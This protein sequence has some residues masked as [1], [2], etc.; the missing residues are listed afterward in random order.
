MS[1]H[2]VITARGAFG[3]DARHGGFE[4]DNAKLAVARLFNGMMDLLPESSSHILY[5]DP[6]AQRIS[7]DGACTGWIG[8][9]PFKLFVVD[10]NI[11][12]SDFQRVVTSYSDRSAGS[13]ARKKFKAD[14]SSILQ[15]DG[16]PARKFLQTLIHKSTTSRSD[17]VL[18]IFAQAVGAFMQMLETTVCASL[19]SRR[20]TGQLDEP[21]E[22]VADGLLQVLDRAVL[23]SASAYVRLKGLLQ[24]MA[25]STVAGENSNHYS[26]CGPDGTTIGTDL[27]LACATILFQ[28][29]G[30]CALM[31]PQVLY[32]VYGG[33][34]SSTQQHLYVCFRTHAVACTCAT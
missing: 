26:I 11:D 30:K 6:A 7:S 2:E 3:E 22:T 25:A 15:L 24:Y 10:N 4:L 29:S 20:I 28:E 13:R 14:C 21:S 33:F 12:L 27:P 1:H 16:Q 31:P 34:M 18:S 19:P 23:A 32:L 17:I 5:C 8:K 9:N